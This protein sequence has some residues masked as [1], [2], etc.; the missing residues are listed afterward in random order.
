MT[1]LKY[2]PTL[3]QFPQRSE[4]LACNPFVKGKLR[5]QLDEYRSQF[6]TEAAHRIEELEQCGPG[7]LELSDVGHRFGRLDGKA[8]F[9]R[10]RCGPTFPGGAP[11]R[12]VKARVDL[13]TRQP[14]RIA[15]KVRQFRAIAR[16]GKQRQV[17][18]RHC[19]ACRTNKELHICQRTTMRWHTMTPRTFALQLAPKRPNVS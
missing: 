11:M 1:G 6:L 2:H 7:I 9:V 5:W 19:P 3:M 12:P 17:L 18:F 16:H 4:E 10:C 8:K 15:L 14:A 13:D